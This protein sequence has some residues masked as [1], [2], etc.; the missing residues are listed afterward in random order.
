MNIT[1]FS[2]FVVLV[3][4]WL[5]VENWKQ[6]LGPDSGTVGPIQ[7][8]FPATHEPMQTTNFSLVET[9]LHRLGTLLG[10]GFEIQPNR[11][12]LITVIE[13][14][15]MNALQNNFPLSTSRTSPM[16]ENHVDGQS[17][18]NQS[19]LMIRHF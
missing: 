18:K 8:Q 3:Y 15:G 16:L 9:L 11:V 17:T 4:V 13:A 10:I 6:A 14:F 7:S 2:S 1:V 5:A 19:Q 12:E